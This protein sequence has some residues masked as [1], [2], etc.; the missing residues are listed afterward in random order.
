MDIRGYIAIVVSCTY[1]HIQ[2]SCPLS[3]LGNRAGEIKHSEIYEF[4]GKDYFHVG[5][6]YI[7]LVFLLLCVV[8]VCVVQWLPAA[9]RHIFLST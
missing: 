1:L 9:R 5:R 8:I 7:Q 3:R 6:L 2:P 4:I